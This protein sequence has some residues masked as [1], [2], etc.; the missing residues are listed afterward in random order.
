MH[1]SRLRCRERSDRIYG[2]IVK[3]IVLVMG[4]IE[5]EQSQRFVTKLKLW[6]SKDPIFS[7]DPQ[8]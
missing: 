3:A 8:R 5:R 2:V 1:F 4:A 7:K 6:G